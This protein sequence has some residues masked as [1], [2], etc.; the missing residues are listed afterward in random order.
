[1]ES[2]E[3]QIESVREDADTRE[4]FDFLVGLPKNEFKLYGQFI[5]DI[6][7]SKACN[8]FRNLKDVNI[9]EM[10]DFMGQVRKFIN[11]EEKSQE[12]TF[13]ESKVEM[14][15]EP[16]IL[17][18]LEYLEPDSDVKEENKTVEAGK[19]IKALNY[20]TEAKQG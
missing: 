4:I 2:I 7:K 18:H 3:K 5:I 11:D 1:M 15:I 9:N 13:L 20:K 6:Y 12:F 19:T 17:G 8:E 14:K 10:K 16:D